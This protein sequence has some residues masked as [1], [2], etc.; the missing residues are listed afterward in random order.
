MSF[1]VF[2]FFR[3]WDPTFLPELICDRV[4]KNLLYIEALSAVTLD[5]WDISPDIS[6]KLSALQRKSNKKEV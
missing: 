5:H 3:F 4:A 1:F 2:F 6:K